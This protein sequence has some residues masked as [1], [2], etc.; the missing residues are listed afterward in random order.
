MAI[1][2]RRPAGTESC[3]YGTRHH[4]GE[5]KTKAFARSNIQAR[6]GLWILPEMVARSR[7]RGSEPWTR[8]LASVRQ[9]SCGAVP[10]FPEPLRLPGHSLVVFSL[11]Y[12]PTGRFLASSGDEEPQPG[13]ARVKVWD[14]ES[15]REAFPVEAFEGD[16]LLFS[17][18]FSRDGRWLVGGGG[19]RKI[20][21]WNGATG[22]KVGVVGEH[23]DEITKLAFS[24]DGRYLASIGD[25]DM[26]N[27]WDATRLDKAQDP[28]R[29]FAGQC[30]DYA[31]DLIAFSPDGSRLAVISDDDTATIH[32][33]GG[34]DRA[35]RL[36]SR[37][38]RPARAG[39]QPRRPLGRFGWKGLRC[40]SLGCPDRQIASDLQKSH[41]QSHSLDILPAS[42]GVVARI[43]QPRWHRKAVGPGNDQMNRRR[44]GVSSRESRAT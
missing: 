22:Q 38:H 21:V 18:A 16:Q 36:V 26:V 15:G 4:Y 11:A 1:A 17:V 34:G 13:K 39:L 5:L 24:P 31:A 12:D 30:D 44:L 33:I 19:D 14:Q 43:G 32:D 10:R 35:V 2:W 23:A 20:K 9:C 6:C 28:V 8:R 27:L 3:M 37:G 29:R 7:S 25:D 41:R 40:Q 42:R